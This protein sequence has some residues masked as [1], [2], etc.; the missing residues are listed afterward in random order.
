MGTDIFCLTFSMLCG[1]HR[2]LNSQ[3]G[4]RNRGVDNHN[5]IS[6]GIINKKRVEERAM[7]EDGDEIRR[8][9]R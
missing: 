6:N 8:E 3:N 5:C 9:Q 7:K 1:V 4:V 2:K